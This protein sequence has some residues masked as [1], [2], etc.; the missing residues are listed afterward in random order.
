MSRVKSGHIT[1]LLLW[2]LAG[3]AQAV[4]L[5]YF[6][7]AWKPLAMQKGAYLEDILADILKHVT[8]CP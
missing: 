6:K 8:T 3:M 1:K 2:I 5:D 4:L 7:P